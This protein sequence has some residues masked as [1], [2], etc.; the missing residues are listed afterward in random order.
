MDKL[1]KKVQ[2][3]A[4]SLDER[5]HAQVLKQFYETI[6][7]AQPWREL[8]NGIK[9]RFTKKSTNVYIWLDDTKEFYLCIWS[10]LNYNMDLLCD[11]Y[12]TDNSKYE[13]LSFHRCTSLF[14]ISEVI[15]TLTYELHH[16]GKQALTDKATALK[17]NH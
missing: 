11:P 4:L 9:S 5:A 17:L 13:V 10:G 15:N 16:N 12:N 2:L 8:Q 3:N 6:I 14:E 1:P 7:K